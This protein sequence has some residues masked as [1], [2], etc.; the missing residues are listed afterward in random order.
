MLVGGMVGRRMPKRA[1]ELGALAVSR[2]QQPGMHF[3][4]VVPGLALHIMPS[5]A[6]SWLLRA[7]VGTKR[8]EMGLGNFPE[9]SLAAAREKARKARELIGQGVDPIEQQR[10]ARREREAA[11]AAA[12]TF[13]RCGQAYVAAHEAGWKSAK[14]AQQWRNT[15]ET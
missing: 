12:W 7:M 9:V 1:R 3:V 6:R 5:G 14:H 10:L 2:L 15:L 13:E 11:Q 8:R 4:G